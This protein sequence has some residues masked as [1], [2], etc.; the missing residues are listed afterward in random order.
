MVLPLVLELSGASFDGLVGSLF[1]NDCLIGFGMS[2]RLFGGLDPSVPIDV[3][4]V[5]NRLG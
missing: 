1:A 3:L 5:N 4:V 2:F